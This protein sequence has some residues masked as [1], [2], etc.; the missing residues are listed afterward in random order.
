MS[1]DV[2]RGKAYAVGDTATPLSAHGRA[3]GGTF[4]G[5]LMA[6][7]EVPTY[8]TESSKLAIIVLYFTLLEKIV[9]KY[10]TIISY[11]DI[12]TQYN[13]NA[14]INNIWNISILKIW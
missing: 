6:S 9:H 11:D 14:I 7:S 4:G 1:K 5:A 2:G 10:N 8:W 12:N 3:G 13:K